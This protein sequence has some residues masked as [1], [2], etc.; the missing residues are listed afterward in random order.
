MDSNTRYLE[1]QHA[2][3]PGVTAE[4]PRPAQTLATLTDPRPVLDAYV[5]RNPNALP[6]ALIALGGLLFF[7]RHNM[8]AAIGAGVPLGLGLVFLYVYS[9]Q[10]RNVGFLV[11]GAILTGLGLGWLT[12]ALTGLDGLGIVGLGA[13][14]CA[15]GYAARPH[16]WALFPGVTLALVGAGMV[17]TSGIVTLWLLPMLLVL[18]GCWLLVAGRVNRRRR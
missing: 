3:A 8:A 16:W 11:P 6:L 12:A 7:G 13:G 15:I 10:G 1:P 2:P 9:Q 4:A 17:A 5:R 18:A 14:F